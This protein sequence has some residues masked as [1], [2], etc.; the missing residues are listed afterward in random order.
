L[1]GIDLGPKTGFVVCWAI[2]PPKGVGKSSNFEEAEPAT[3]L[4]VIEREY[5]E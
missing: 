3:R 2:G 1:S 4:G 5:N